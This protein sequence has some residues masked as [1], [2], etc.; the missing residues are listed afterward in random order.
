MAAWSEGYF[1]DVQYTGN[2]FPYMAPSA[3]S[4]ALMRRGVRPPPLKAGAT[5]MEL[6]CGQG[7][8]LNM[9]AA[10]NP[11]LQFIGLDFHPGQ[12]ANAR[13]LAAEAGLSNIRFEDLSFE[14]VLDL[15]EGRLP[16]C[17]AIAAHGVLSWIS[18]ENRAR[19]VRI[20]DR[21][22]EPGGLAALSY[23]AYPGW[24]AL[25]PL[26]QFVKEFVV[27]AGGDPQKAV[28]EALNAAHKMVET[29]AGAF[30]RSP[31][32]KSYVSQKLK[33]RPA[34]LLHEFVHE[35]FHPLFHAELARELDAAR[36]TFAAQAHV[37]ED[38]TSLMVPP[39]LQ[40]AV[41]TETDPLWRETL[42]DY[43][44]DRVFRRDIYVRGHNPL[45]PRERAT[46]LGPVRFAL[47]RPAE[48]IS[49]QFKVP[50][51]GLNGDPGTYGAIV[52]ALAHGPKRYDELT[53]LPAVNGN[54]PLL[55][56][57][58]GLLIETSA[59]HP[60]NDGAP[61]A[62]PAKAFNG[63]LLDRFRRET[64]AGLVAAPGVGIG[65]PVTFSEQLSLGR[66]K[67]DAKAA[68]RTGWEMLQ[69]AGAQLQNDGKVVSGQADT[70]AVILAQMAAFDE[71]R[72]PLLAALGV[73]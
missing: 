63:V 64:S 50:I 60:M 21:H 7:F 27:R 51:G 18:A 31:Q 9:L 33:A 54:E 32:V 38:M 11:H 29:G 2:F 30:A 22:L 44:A 65:V 14:Q 59:I 43:A 6:G 17:E 55:M 40:P 13:A 56:K 16:K 34:Y 52:G 58:L 48:R 72:R 39:A 47:L 57:A 37:T 24:A 53:A 69:R 10:A 23:N 36:L 49:F 8:G 71:Q 41:E 35:E 5:Y 20:L 28:V 68:A 12:I 46:L 45:T 61:D 4:F 1:T 70:E 73:A 26:Q 15:P 19:I 66:G 25:L 62:A 42:A 3:L 67:D